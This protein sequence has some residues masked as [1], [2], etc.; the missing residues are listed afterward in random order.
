M[1]GKLGKETPSLGPT[2]RFGHSP[3]SEPKSILIA[4]VASSPFQAHHSSRSPVGG[5]LQSGDGL[6]PEGAPAKQALH[7]LCWRGG[8]RHQRSYADTSVWVNQS[9]QILGDFSQEG[10]GQLQALVLSVFRFHVL[11]K[12]KMIR[13][14]HCGSAVMSRTSV[15]VDA[16]LTPGLAQRVKDPAMP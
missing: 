13:N 6:F 15:H 2:A 9:P 10:G 4:L 14:S 11:Q 12:S 5:N 3:K 16:G 8:V 1:L 7:H